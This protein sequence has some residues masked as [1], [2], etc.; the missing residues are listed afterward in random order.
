MCQ[1]S[2]HLQFAP[3]LRAVLSDSKTVP[4]ITLKTGLRFVNTD[5][6]RARAKTCGECPRRGKAWRL[7]FSVGVGAL[8]YSQVLLNNKSLRDVFCRA[9]D[10]GLVGPTDV[11]LSHPQ[12]HAH[13]PVDVIN[14]NPHHAFSVGCRESR[15]CSR[16]TY[17]EFYFTK[18]TGIRRKSIRA[19][20]W[21]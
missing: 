21:T 1:L 10:P 9:L 18:Y 16:H 7:R 3:L 5:L 6:R 20:T 17:Q 12:G 11:R 4:R 19:R 8:C 14:E 15:R 13:A 2:W